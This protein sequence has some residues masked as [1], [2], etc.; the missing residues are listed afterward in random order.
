MRIDTR[1][2]LMREGYEL[3]NDDPILPEDDGGDSLE[4]AK[5][6]VSNLL[7][8]NILGRALVSLD[9]EDYDVCG[10]DAYVKFES[11]GA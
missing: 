10:Y 9:I 2:N 1:A 8:D 6:W 4:H 3:V 11:E 7:L 5:A